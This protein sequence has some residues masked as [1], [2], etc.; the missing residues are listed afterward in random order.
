MI[1]VS[2]IMSCFKSNSKLLKKSIESLQNQSFKKFELI[3]IDDGISKICKKIVRN[4]ASKDKRIKILQN[5]KNMGLPYSLNKAIKYSSGEYIVRAD[6]D[7]FSHKNRIELQVNFL[8]KNKDISVLGSNAKINLIYKKKYIL[9]KFPLKNKNII[10]TLPFY[11]PIIHS[12][13]CMRKKIFRD[14]KYDKNFLKAQDYKLWQILAKN[15]IQF[16]NLPQKLITLNKLK[17][18]TILDI[19]YEIKVKY[20]HNSLF[21]NFVLSINIPIILVKVLINN[22]F[23]N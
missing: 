6:D 3:I 22:F 18:P 8:R 17:P 12:S 19:I 10:K 14:Y 16:E 4:Q 2:I 1:K 5:K 13:V 11:N 21:R 9:S 7:D 15:K 23:Y 20:R